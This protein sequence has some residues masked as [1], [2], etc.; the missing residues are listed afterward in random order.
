[1]GDSE[2]PEIDDDDKLTPG[3]L[4]W[5]FSNK[6]SA[7]F[8]DLIGSTKELKKKGKNKKNNHFGTKQYGTNQNEPKLK[9]K[10][11]KIKKRKSNESYNMNVK[12]KRKYKKKKNQ[13]MIL[14]KTGSCDDIKNFEIMM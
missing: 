1:M 8:G 13:S 6:S 12:K 4:T 2:S 7:D 5:V 9:I 11:L 3:R 10:S 14:M